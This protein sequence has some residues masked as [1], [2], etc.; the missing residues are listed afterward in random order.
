VTVP[1]RIE[2]LEKHD[3]TIFDC[4]VEPLNDYFLTRVRQDI[5][6]HVTKCYVAVDN[7]TEQIAGYYT[8]AAGAVV[9]NDLP[10]QIVKRLP[11]YPSVPI[12]RI[13]RLAVDWRYQGRKLGS[14]LL[15]DALKRS[16]DSEIAAFAAVVDAKDAD[17][18]A[19]YEHHG[20]MILPS[21][22]KT[23]FLPLSDALKRLAR[24]GET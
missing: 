6:R 23:L 3:R 11:R 7:E 20:F 5:R 17:A 12:V 1:F 14:A 16:I 22:D 2:S 24:R 10:E 9:L 4:G 13:G 19:F 15:A 18:V 8:L 21:S